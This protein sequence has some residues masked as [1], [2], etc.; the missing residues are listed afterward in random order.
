MRQYPQEQYSSFE[1]GQGMNRL[2]G[3]FG[4]GRGRNRRYNFGGQRQP[5]FGYGAQRFNQQ[6]NQQSP[7]TQGTPQTMQPGTIPSRQD[8]DPFLGAKGK[9]KIDPYTGQAIAKDDRLTPKQFRNRQA[10]DRSWDLAQGP[11]LQEASNFQFENLPASIAGTGGQIEQLTGAASNLLGAGSQTLQQGGNLV[12]S[13]V[14]NL[15]G[16]QQQIQGAS[17]GAGVDR[18]TAQ[19]QLQELQRQAL[20]PELSPD[21]RALFQQRADERLSEVNS[22]EENLFDAYQR[23]DASNAA[24]LAA[25]GV[26]DSTT[27]SN[28]MAET[29]RRLGL[30]LNA[31]TQQANELSRQEQLG[32]RQRIGETATQF[33]GLQAQQASS[34]G[35]LLANLLGQQAGIGGNIGQLGLGQQG[36]GAELSQAGLSGMGTAGQLGL[37]ARGQEADLQQ[38]EL[39]TRIMGD[40]TQLQNIQSLLNQ[41]L[42]RKATR[43]G[44]EYQDALMNM[45]MNPK[46]S[47][48]LMNWLIPST[49]WIDESAGW[50]GPNSR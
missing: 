33:G 31:L 4:G 19:Q 11:A 36:I 27:G 20:S 43:Q 14:Q 10:T 35:D 29:S 39:S 12:G 49:S 37:A 32:E 17:S 22:L 24:Q 18:A 13:S 42:G 48:S 40:Q 21:Q 9:V 2:Q 6:Y 41:I 26:L 45:Y 28:T 50:E 44:M 5:N 1:Q 23:Q 8:L 30:D 38:A 3:F 25:K 34:A 46:D 7:T 15:L 47:M 16:T